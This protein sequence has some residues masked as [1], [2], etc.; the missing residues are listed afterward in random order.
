MDHDPLP[1]SFGQ[2]AELFHDED[3]APSRE[4]ANR[5][6]GE[7]PSGLCGGQLTVSM[8]EYRPA[9]YHR[10]HDDKMVRQRTAD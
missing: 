7:T 4:D 9:R 8:A 3:Q 10:R 1:S 5:D 6:I 2:Y